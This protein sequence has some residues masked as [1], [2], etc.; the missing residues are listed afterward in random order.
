MAEREQAARSVKRNMSTQ[1]E[2]PGCKSGFEEPRVLACSHTYCKRCM[3][4]LVKKAQQGKKSETV[5]CPECGVPTEIPNG[6][7]TK[8]TY[9]FS[10]Q[11]VTDL[12]KYYS[13]PEPVPVIQCGSCRRYGNKDAS[14]AVARCS[15]CSMFLCKE[16]F[17]VHSL[18]DFTKLHTTLTLTER[19][20]TDYFFSCLTPDEKGIR[21]CQ[22]HNWRPYTHFC[23]TCSKGVCDRCIQQDHR[24]HVYSKPELIRPDYACYSD[25]LNLRT[26]KLLWQTEYAIDTVQDLMSG[27]QLLAAT[28]IEEVVRTQEALSSALESRQSQL[29]QEIERL[30]SQ[31]K[32]REPAENEDGT[33]G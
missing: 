26:G 13:S 4:R 1:L 33:S 25:V 22:N 27:V 15:S 10:I 23:I 9:N 11:H 8:L 32:C 6:D 12:M 24:S 7:I 17:D 14:P 16:C 31:D 18:D 29:L 30:H 28:Q 5:Y 19:R 21:N 3:E 2:C 20:N